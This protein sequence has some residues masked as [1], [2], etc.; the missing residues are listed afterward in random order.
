M[1]NSVNIVP[2]T[3]TFYMIFSNRRVNQLTRR[4]CLF[5]FVACKYTF[6]NFFSFNCYI[7]MG[8]DIAT[9][10]KCAIA[11]TSMVAYKS[12]DTKSVWNR[13]EI[14]EYSSIAGNM[15]YHWIHAICTEIF[16]QHIYPKLPM[17]FLSFAYSTKIILSFVFSSKFK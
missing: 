6:Q 12:V 8:N 1:I 5:H 7:N 17:S 10:N 11:T 2:C 14:E 3:Q 15:G 9:S 16:F 13:Y 4:T